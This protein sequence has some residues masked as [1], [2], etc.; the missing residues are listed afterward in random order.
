M[1]ACPWAPAVISL[2][3]CIVYAVSDLPSLALIFVNT[4]APPAV[5]LA[6]MTIDSDILAIA[7]AALAEFG[8]RAVEIMDKRAQD[9]R[10]AGETEGEV[11]WRR[12]AAAVL[13]MAK[14]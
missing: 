1:P 7:R 13:D 9:H 12:V 10:L 8:P 2:N 3:S 14:G 5:F 11:L 4:Q 6:G